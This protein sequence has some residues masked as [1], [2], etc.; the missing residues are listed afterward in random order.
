LNLWRRL[1]PLYW[2]PSVEGTFRS[3]TGIA[4]TSALSR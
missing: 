2:S 3:R 4:R 1:F